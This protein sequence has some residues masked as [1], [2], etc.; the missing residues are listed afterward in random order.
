MKMP[1]N[2]HN[3]ATT[4]VLYS[5]ITAKITFTVI[6]GYDFLE[7]VKEQSRALKAAKPWHQEISGCGQTVETVSSETNRQKT[8][9]RD[10][11]RNGLQ[12]KQ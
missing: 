11:P 5:D 9:S 3:L 1:T 8:D 12:T 10:C 7:S 2:I 4:T 6:L